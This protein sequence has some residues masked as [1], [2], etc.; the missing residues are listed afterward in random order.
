[1]EE[2]YYSLSYEAFVKD[3]ILLLIA[4]LQIS[5]EYFVSIVIWKPKQED[6]MKNNLGSW[7]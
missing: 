4:N 1:M 5:R 6:G 3:V 7:K 2:I